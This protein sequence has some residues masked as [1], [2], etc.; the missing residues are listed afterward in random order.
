M[1]SGQV[2]PPP[3]IHAGLM[4]GT[5]MDAVDGVLIAFDPHGHPLQTL[6]T[7]SLPMPDALRAQ[8][9]DLQHGCPDELRRACLA[10]NALSDLYADCIDQLLAQAPL[11]PTR[12]RAIGAHGQT[13]RH[14]PEDGYSLQ[15]LNGA[16]L[17]ARTGIDV[18]CDLRSADIAAGGQG[19]PLMPAF[20]AHVFA[21]LNHRCGILNLGG[22]ANL[23]VIDP[24]TTPSG[25]FGF[26]IGPANTLLDTW[27]EANLQRRFDHRGQ[28]A[29]S[30][31]PIPSLLD[32]L[33]TEPYFALPPPK[34][35]G[36]DLFNLQWLAAHLP[37]GHSHSPVDIQATLLALTAESCARAIRAHRLEAVYICGGGAEN[38][39]LI[40]AI[41]QRVQPQ[42]RV[43]T[44]DALGIAP[45]AVEA[46][47]FAW[48]AHQRVH[49]IP[50]ALPSITGALHSSILGAW[51]AAPDARTAN[52]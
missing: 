41:R 21:E 19:A 52:V 11:P 32:A 22:I 13:V 28:W 49:N 2:S 37:A 45:Q 43:E 23:S 25:V 24:A 42:T 27:I 34:S 9:A 3:E 15:L 12:V 18:I 35:T 4:S 17:A 50:I 48:L 26:D 20:H 44:T 1:A 39:H 10:A 6:A 30:G 38:H 33:L 47:G 31:Q 40:E 5:S 14:F 36:R 8:L 46:S 29:A 16:R 51:H 7:A